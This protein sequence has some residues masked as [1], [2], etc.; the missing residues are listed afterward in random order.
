MVVRVF[1]FIFY[2]LVRRFYGVDIRESIYV[3][4]IFY[5]LIVRRERYYFRF[6]FDSI[7]V[8]VSYG[9]VGYAW[10]RGGFRG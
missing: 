6:I 7:F 3:V 2:G 8:L 5:L 4:F 9:I 10:E 1:I